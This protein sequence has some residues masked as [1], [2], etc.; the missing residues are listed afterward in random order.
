MSRIK[1]K[2]RQYLFKNKLKRRHKSKKELLKE[3]S[4]LMMLGLF[5][6]LINYFIP[7]KMILF[8]SF[9]ENILYILKNLW[10]ILL[11]SLEI[12]IV[13]LISFSILLSIFFLVGSVNRIIKVML[14]DSR[15]MSNR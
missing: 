3:S 1:N 15:K 8:I 13:L 4:L 10:E 12:L 7:Q 5:L 9:K 14:S 2:S 11:S 6:L